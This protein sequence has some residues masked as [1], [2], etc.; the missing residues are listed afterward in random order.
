VKDARAIALGPV[1]CS[2]HD[3]Y[4]LV[5]NGCERCARED[6]EESNE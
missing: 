1:F 6:L 3:G 5:P 2:E 4:P